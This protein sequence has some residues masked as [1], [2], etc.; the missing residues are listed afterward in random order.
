[1]RSFDS[2]AFEN[3][4]DVPLKSLCAVQS[5]DD[6]HARNHS[7]YIQQ[8]FTGEESTNIFSTQKE[9]S[10][11]KSI[12]CHYRPL[13][14]NKQLLS[15]NKEPRRKPTSQQSAKQVAQHPLNTTVK[16]M[17]FA[18]H[19]YLSPHTYHSK[20]QKK[21]IEKSKEGHLSTTGLNKSLKTNYQ[22]SI[23]VQPTY[24]K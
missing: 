10:L 24:F 23:K 3:L 16:P 15:I 11:K 20:P 5:V 18:S 19:P 14:I 8:Q 21:A 6:G 17:Q 13:H 9:T 22:I 2:A 12:Y 7:T 4:L 1:M